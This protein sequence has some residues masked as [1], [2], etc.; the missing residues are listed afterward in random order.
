M[1]MTPAPFWLMIAN[2]QLALTAADRDHRV[3]R[4]DARLQRGVDVLAENYARRNPLQGPRAI[5]AD[6]P[7]A[8]DWLAKRVDNAANQGIADRD[9]R[10]T[11]GRADLVALFDVGVLTHDDD[12]DRILFEVEGE[13]ENTA[14]CELDE[15]ARHH[16]RKPVYPRD[17]VSDFDDG[18]D[19]AD[20][21]FLFKTGDLRPQDVANLSCT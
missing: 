12:T 14:L 21:Q 4:L 19:V 10:N 2:D 13:A 20:R 17:A 5:G 15:F 8:I 3:D 11:A 18:A 16:L 7:F 9:R 6:R 1:Q